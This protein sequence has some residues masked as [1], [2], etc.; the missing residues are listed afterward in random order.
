MH[1]EECVTATKS[2]GTL[3]NY[4]VEKAERWAFQQVLAK[5]KGWASFLSVMLQGKGV[6]C[7]RGR[8]GEGL[9]ARAPRTKKS[10]QRA[11]SEVETRR[12]EGSCLAGTAGER[13]WGRQATGGSADGIQDAHSCALMRAQHSGRTLNPATL[14]GTGCTRPEPGLR[15]RERVLATRPR[16]T[17]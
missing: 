10:A 15:T 5:E 4:L 14:H 9:E 6:G 11:E 2:H 13:R 3:F 12:R 17:G 8:R 1:L 16:G 7:G